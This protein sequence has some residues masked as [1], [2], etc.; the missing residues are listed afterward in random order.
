MTGIGWAVVPLLLRCRPPTIPGL[1]VAVVVDPVDRV[2]R[3]WLLA[4]VGQE[5]RE[6]A[7]ALGYPDTASAVAGVTRIQRVRASLPYRLPHGVEWVLAS[8]SRE[9]V[10]RSRR[11]GI[12]DGSPCRLLGEAATGARAS[13]PKMAARDRRYGAAVT[14]AEPPAR[15][16]GIGAQDLEATIPLLGEIHARMGKA[17]A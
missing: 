10:L 4:H 17:A 5:D 12:P 8:S 13:A 14:E 11:L 15:I 6:V 1:V 16:G 2:L 7:P 3:R 9:P